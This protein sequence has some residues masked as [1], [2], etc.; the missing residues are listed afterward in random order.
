MHHATKKP[1]ASNDDVD[2]ARYFYSSITQPKE[3]TASGFLGR[4]VLA[5][6]ALSG[7]CTLRGIDPIVPRGREF[8]TSVE[9]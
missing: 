7:P 9:S 5:F 6:N 3:E 8:C 4:E 2:E 1:T